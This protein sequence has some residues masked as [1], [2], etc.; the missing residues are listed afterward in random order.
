MVIKIS[1][2]LFCSLT[3]VLSWTLLHKDLQRREKGTP[4][5]C[6]SVADDSWEAYIFVPYTN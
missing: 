1:F 3:P 5:L 2:H 6:G 4:F